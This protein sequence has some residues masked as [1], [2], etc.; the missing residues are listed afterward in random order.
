MVTYYREHLLSNFKRKK[1]KFTNTLMQCKSS[2][3]SD[4][5]IVEFD[6]NLFYQNMMIDNILSLIALI[7]LKYGDLK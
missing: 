7:E 6:I 1:I 4:N 3:K 5:L 2:P